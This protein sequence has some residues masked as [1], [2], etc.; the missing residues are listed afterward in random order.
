MMEY[1][2]CGLALS[3]VDVKGLRSKLKSLNTPSNKPK[4]AFAGMDD[5]EQHNAERTRKIKEAADPPE[6]YPSDFLNTPPKVDYG[7]DFE[8]PDSSMA[9]NVFLDILDIILYD[10]DH[11]FF[12]YRPELLSHVRRYLAQNRDPKLSDRPVSPDDHEENK[13]AMTPEDVKILQRELKDQ[14]L[15]EEK[16]VLY[17]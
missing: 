13:I 8:K 15:E 11:D 10:T 12:G 6:K 1:C 7:T 5:E 14:I 3:G 17:V 2:L 4:S 9:V 16:A